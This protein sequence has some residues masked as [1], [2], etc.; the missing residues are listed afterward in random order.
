MALANRSFEMSGNPGPLFTN[1]NIGLAKTVEA[2]SELGVAIGPGGR[3]SGP[4]NDCFHVF[5][6]PQ[7]LEPGTVTRGSFKIETH[8]STDRDNRMSVCHPDSPA[9]PHRPSPARSRA[10]SDPV[11]ALTDEDLDL[12]ATCCD[13]WW[14]RFHRLFA[15]DC[16]GYGGDHCI[17][18]R[19]LVE[20]LME[21]GVDE[22]D[23]VHRVVR[24]SGLACNASAGAPWQTPVVRDAVTA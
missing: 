13:R 12:I 14:P 24:A 18:V 5:G 3:S 4:R 21:A 17:A 2:A 15:G 8:Y 7:L 19:A 11:G 10:T 1:E 16:S 22:P 23:A 9:M 20:Y 6:I